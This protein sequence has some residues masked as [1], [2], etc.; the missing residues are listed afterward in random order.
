MLRRPPG[1]L[2]EG[3]PDGRLEV[4]L[5]AAIGGGEVRVHRD[6]PDLF[7]EWRQV[8]RQV[9]QFDEHGPAE[10]VPPEELGGDPRALSHRGPWGPAPG[11]PV[12][13]L[14]R[15]DGDRFQ[16]AVALDPLLRVGVLEALGPEGLDPDPRDQVLKVRGVSARQGP[17]QGQGPPGGAGEAAEGVSLGRRGS[18]ELVG[19]V[20]DEE[21]EPS[22]EPSP[23]ELGRGIGPRPP[24]VGLPERL[25]AGDALPFAPFEVVSTHRCP[26]PVDLGGAT[27][28]TA[29]EGVARSREDRRPPGEGELGPVTAHQPDFPPAGP[30][31]VA[32]LQ[33]EAIGDGSDRLHGD[34]RK[35]CQDFTPPL[36]HQVPGAHDER[37]ERPAEER[38]HDAGGHQ[39]LARPELA[40]EKESPPSREGSGQGRDR[41][42]LGGVGSS[43]ERG[44]PRVQGHVRPPSGHRTATWGCAGTSPSR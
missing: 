42:G 24:G 20:G 31:A 44:E 18:L 27:P 40:H 8:Q 16:D 4:V 17:R 22:R 41:V 25:L 34:I 21:V 35:R 10:Q 30:S 37:P 43:E 38:V 36:S 28:G 1:A 12:I 23:D 11:H 2:P 19:L 33:A 29:A 7:V 5:E 14:P 15:G 32:G 9:R 13:P 39:G 26:V 3:V 6:R